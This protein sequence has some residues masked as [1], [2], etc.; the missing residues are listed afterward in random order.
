MYA[1]ALRATTISTI[2]Q[3]LIAFRNAKAT[4]KTDIV[5]RPESAIV[6]GATTSMKPLDIVYRSAR[7]AVPMEFANYLER[8]YVMKITH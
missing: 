7:K 1:N 4:V 5:D 2:C 6:P 8:A 3:V